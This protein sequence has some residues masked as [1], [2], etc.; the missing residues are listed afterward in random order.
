MRR[1]L[2]IPL[3]FLFLAL[4]PCSAHSAHSSSSDNCDEWSVEDVHFH[5]RRA[6]RDI[7]TDLSNCP[8]ASHVCDERE[9]LSAT[10]LT[11]SD[12]C[13][14]QS[15]RCANKGWRLAVNGTIVDKVRCK[16][17]QW[18]SSG[19]AAPSFVCAK[20]DPSVPATSTE[21]IT[22]VKV[23]ECIDPPAPFMCEVAPVNDPSFSAVCFRGQ[24]SNLYCNS[25]DT[26]LVALTTNPGKPT[27]P[28][29]YY[30]LQGS[31]L[32]N[33]ETQKYE[34]TTLDISIEV[35]QV[36]CMQCPHMRGVATTTFQGSHGDA[37]FDRC[38]I[39][40]PTGTLK[41]YTLA[42]EFFNANGGFAYYTYTGTEFYFV[43]SAGIR[44]V[45]AD[46]YCENI[47]PDN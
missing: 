9:A 16:G 14:C 3:V 44:F 8:A 40:C 10:V 41:G 20:F 1:R 18:V 37:V 27:D 19:R 22:T 30:T 2:A 4:V 11:A 21:S 13:T 6:C 15:L 36:S 33:Q 47:P 23:E 45:N 29:F 12:Q 39:S 43:D 24:D 17:R 42:D 28:P 34:M 35:N 38:I 5:E 32:C 7:T 31:G 25:G 26:V 46:F